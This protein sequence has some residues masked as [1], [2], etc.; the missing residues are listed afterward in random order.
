MVHPSTLCVHTPLGLL[1]KGLRL[2]LLWG[3]PLQGVLPFCRQ[4]ELVYCW[5]KGQTLSYLTNGCAC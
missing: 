4:H 1:Q 5:L 2:R 3:N